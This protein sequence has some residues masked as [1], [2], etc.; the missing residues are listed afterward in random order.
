MGQDDDSAWAWNT[1]QDKDL[2]SQLVADVEDASRTTGSLTGS[3]ANTGSL[4]GSLAHTGSLTNTGS[5][6]NTGSLTGSLANTGSLTGSLTG[7][8]AAEVENQMQ[9]DDSAWAWNT[10]QDKDLQS[11]LVADVEDASRTTGSLTGSLANTGSLT[12][13]LAES[14]DGESLARMLL[15][16][17]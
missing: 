13:S 3:L 6:A 7:E 16:E 5:L 1:E 4:T 2:Q 9:D 12:G 17:Y 15:D 8:H 10:E 11:Q 14:L